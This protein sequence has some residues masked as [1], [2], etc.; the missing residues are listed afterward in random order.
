MFT[1][2]DLLVVVFMIMAAMTVLSL[3][4][5]FLI[6]NKTAKKVFFYIVCAFALYTAYI[7]FRIGL[8]GY[9]QSQI[10]ISFLTVIMVIGA[11][12]LELLSKRNDKFSLYA[13]VLSAAALMI[14]FAN[15]L[16][17]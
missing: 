1:S 8:S 11:V 17:I 7:G 14:G 2:L 16:L 15:A 3:C 4:L 6:R 5:M 13:R 12:T 10:A 9:F